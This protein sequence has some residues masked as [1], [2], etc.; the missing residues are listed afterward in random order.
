[1]SDPLNSA[2]GQAIKIGSKDNPGNHYLESFDTKTGI[3]T[4]INDKQEKGRPIH[5]WQGDLAEMIWIHPFDHT[6]FK[7]PNFIPF[8]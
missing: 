4:M 3:Q 1:V 5:T 2:Y 8:P 6:P 7:F